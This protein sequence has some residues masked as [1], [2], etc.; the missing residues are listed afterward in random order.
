MMRAEVS[1]FSRSHAL[2]Y[3][4]KGTRYKSKLQLRINSKQ[5]LYS[6]PTVVL[7]GACLLMDSNV[8][9]WIVEPG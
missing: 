9:I 7:L 3:L 8:S 6:M 5:A 4:L 2:I 1:H